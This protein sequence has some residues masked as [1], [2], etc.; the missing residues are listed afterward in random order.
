MMS[1]EMMDQALPAPMRIG[2][3][4]GL[5]DDSFPPMRTG[6]RDLT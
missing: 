1:D 5:I 2:S 6:L 3:A 4:I